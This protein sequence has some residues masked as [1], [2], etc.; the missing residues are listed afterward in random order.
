M[1]FLLIGISSVC[2]GILMVVCLHSLVT[3]IVY[4]ELSLLGFL[5]IVTELSV[6]FDDVF[7]LA[8]GILIMVIAACES[9]VGLVLVSLLGSSRV[10]SGIKR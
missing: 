1:S 2:L 5:V 6:L 4:M 3:I 7:G 9:A 10:Y 8:I